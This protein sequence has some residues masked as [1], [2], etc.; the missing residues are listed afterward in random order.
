MSLLPAR[1]AGERY[2]SD[3]HG[4]PLAFWRPALSALAARHELPDGPW[5]R[6][7][8]GRNV[9]FLSPGV[10]IK[11]GPPCWPGD[12]AREAEALRFVAGKLP[13]RTP[14]VLACGAFD[15]WEYLVSARCPGTNLY[16]LWRELAASDRIALARQHG[17]LMAAIHALPTSALPA[18][19]AFDWARMLAEQRAELTAALARS[20]LNTELVAQAAAYV[21]SAEAL[22]VELDRT[23]LVHGDLSHLNVLVE[24]RDGGW[25]ITGLLDWGDVKIGPWSHELI[26]PGVHM[27]RGDRDALH[28]WYRGYG[29]IARAVAGAVAHL[30]TVRALLYYAEEFASIL[31]H[32]PDGAACRDWPAVARCLWQLEEGYADLG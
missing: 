8:L 11:L 4:Q 15:G 10:V 30:V 1:V 32:L 9:V 7:A 2:V 24:R 5:Q 20:G 23:V 31:G 21:A 6:A 18:A 12:I 26:S 19:L 16:E 17:A 29:R 28:A 14:A 3:V 27:Y 13:V 22:T 25:A